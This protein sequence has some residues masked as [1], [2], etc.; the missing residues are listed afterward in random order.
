MYQL[1]HVTKGIDVIS[2]KAPDTEHGLSMQDPATG[3]IVI[4][5]ATTQH[6]MRQ[7]SSIA[8]ELG[9]VI[10]GDLEQDEPV[11][12]G[13]RSPAEIRA[14]AFARHLLLPL[15]A[16]QRRF[17]GNRNSTG[18]TLANLSDLVQEFEVSAYIAA[19]QLR[20]LKVIDADTCSAWSNWSAANLATTFGWGSQYR[21]LVADSSLS[22]APQALMT[23]A[24]EGYRRGVLSI[25]ELAA[26]YGRDP[27]DLE[28]ELGA[29]PP[30]GATDDWDDDAPLFPD[31]DLEDP[32]L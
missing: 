10:A 14:D 8:H 30:A 7:R 21:A 4:A 20:T 11:T 17:G 27:A 26:W 16:V 9:H 23:R 24:V 12:P 1:V 2:I 29:P 6:P 31:G 32:A 18:V 22:R 3:R 19:I 25:N 28:S 15:E 13:E 5:V